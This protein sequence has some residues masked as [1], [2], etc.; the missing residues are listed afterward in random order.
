MESLGPSDTST[1]DSLP[2]GASKTPLSFGASFP[3]TPSGDMQRSDGRPTS[4]A[5][6]S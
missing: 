6:S 1:G 5:G 3:S 4:T 2:D